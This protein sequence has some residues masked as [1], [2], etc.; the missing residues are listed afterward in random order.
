MQHL[1]TTLLSAGA[2]ML[3]ASTAALALDMPVLSNQG[4][5]SAGHPLAVEAGL[6]VLKDGGTACD[7]AVAVAATLS[8]VMPEMLGPLGSGYALIYEADDKKLSAIDY[9][10]VAP[11][12]TTPAQFDM[13]K[14][15]RGILA[16]T[17]PGNIKGWEE[18]HKR[19]GVLPW[20]SLWT[21]AIHYADPGYPLDIVAANR[22][23]QYV[24]ELGIQETW[25]KELLINGMEPP[26]AGYVL[27]RPEMAESLRILAKEG[28]A[29]VYSGSIGDK[30]VAYMEAEGGLITKQDLANYSVRWS[31]PIHTTYRGYDVYGSQPSAS[32]ITWMQILKIMEGYDVVSLKHNSPEYLHLFLEATKQAYLDAYRYNGDPQFV[33]VPVEKLLSNEYAEE[34][35]A[36]IKEKNVQDIKPAKQALLAPNFQN[37]ATSHMVVI[38]KDGNAISSTNTHGNIWGAGVIVPGTGLHMSNGMDWF[39]IDVNVWTGET[40]GALGMAPG[41]RNRWTLSPGMIF[42]DGKLFMLVGGAGA[43]TTMWGIAQPVINVIDFGMNVQEALDAPRVRWGDGSHYTGGT[44]VSLERAVP[45]EVGQ[46]LAGLGYQVDDPLK[47]RTGGRGTTNMIVID[48]NTGA[49]WGG[50]A[51]NGKDFVAGY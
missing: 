23:K 5:I 38:D 22:I 41:K 47:P 34:V 10:G 40:P 3:I 48:Q 1:R 11:A 15:K 43:E 32:S 4:M 36:T 31:D 13:A 9:N 24:G 45:A 17:V 28:A 50:A 19:C 6:R 42:K 14:K 35:R 49:Y 21:E 2:S 8:V 30:I 46:A 26:P 51:P 27:R 25:A 16:P 7:A 20:E 44:T 39:D 37:H 18:I 33:D 12:A 29:A